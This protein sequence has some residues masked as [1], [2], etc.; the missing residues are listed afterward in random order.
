MGKIRIF[1]V[2]LGLL[3]TGAAVAD[4]AGAEVAF[5][6]GVKAAENRAHIDAAKKFAEAELLADA[7]DLKLKAALQEADSY[8]A[9][10]YRGKEFE[11][12]EK[13]IAR[14]PTR[15]DYGALVDR[16]FAIGDAYFNGYSDPAFWSLRFIPWLTDKSRM[17]EVYEAALKHAP[18]AKAGAEARLRLAV[19]YLKQAQNEK[20]LK[21]LRE[22]IRYYPGSEAGRYA[23]LE[24]GNA[25]CE[26]ARSGDGD[27]RY[28]DEAMTVFQE[29]REKY[30]DLSENEWVNQCEIVARDAYAERLYNIA[31]FYSREGRNDPAETYLVEVLRR[32]PDTEAAIRSEALL[33]ELDKTYFPEQIEPAV[34]SRYPKYETL[35]F[36]KETHQLVLA[37][38][39]SDGRF[40][41]PIYDLN[42]P[43]NQEARP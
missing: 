43:K 42:L 8:R 29:F 39:N 22:I 12:L 20:A 40:L 1:A 9:A 5:A 10:G 36:P 23:M 19:H 14:Y 24:L 2:V 21:L 30:P 3:A 38:E 33:T 11:A 26:M 35:A 27:G 17:S 13:I 32:F 6:A 16:E 41:L 7:P 31:Q 25:L 37:P 34:P 15:V 4:D 18:F 28:F